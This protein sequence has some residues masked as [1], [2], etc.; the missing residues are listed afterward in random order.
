MLS[1][2][3]SGSGEEIPPAISRLLDFAPNS[4][5]T[6]YSGQIALSIRQ[7]RDDG[8][9]PDFL[10]VIS[11]LEGEAIVVA[12]SL[13]LDSSSLPL[14]LAD[15]HVAP[16]L[17]RFQ[18]QSLVST[19]GEAW[20]E[21]RDHPESA[22]A[23]GRAVI[24][25]IERAILDVPD[26]VL[27]GIVDACH[28]SSLELV[29]PPELVKGLIHQGTKV[30]LGGGSKS[31]KT[32]L[33]LDLS[34]C[35]AYG[36][37]WLGFTTIPGRILFVNLE[38]QPAFFQHRIQAIS[39]ARGIKQVAGKLD[40]WNLRGH[41]ASYKIILPQFIERV[42]STQYCLIDLD[43]IYK[44]Y[45]NTDENSAGEVAQL[46]NELERVCVQTGAC[47]LFGAH[48]SKGNQ[49][50]KESID[51]VSGSGVFT[52]DPDSLI[53]FTRHEEEG[54]FVVEPILRNLPPITPFVVRWNHPLMERDEDLDPSK[55]K[56]SGG[57]TKTH[58]K[59]DIFN[60]L[61]DSGLTTSEWQNLAEK[62]SGVSRR[63]FYRL[64]ME[65]KEASAII[66][67]HIN[68]TWKPVRRQ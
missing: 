31:F 21:A 15:L 16:L 2:L 39:H 35:C 33:Q 1:S 58:S 4:F 59:N 11:L 53:N 40:I 42:K 34:L 36:L 7:A 13:L 68:D 29:Q 48:Y 26:Q 25:V 45:G 57:R 62:S 50:S 60:L 64:K 3:L 47:V 12:Q 24:K 6:P 8:K 52:R 38:I 63:T 56:Q 23:V 18:S 66:F 43:P 5:V 55:L 54:A 20:Q 9:A 67:S 22:P 65:L 10:K 32:W 37:P 46:M 61:P 27:P 44:L 51:R 49:A 30:M 19:L 28:F 17:L 14:G 41:N